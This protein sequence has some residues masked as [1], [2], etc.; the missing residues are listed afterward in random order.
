MALS[1]PA[2]ADRATTRAGR[3]SSRES[4]KGEVWFP[5]EMRF[6]DEIEKA[7]LDPHPHQVRWT[8]ARSTPT[9]SPRPGWS[10]RAGRGADRGARARDHGPESHRPASSPLA[11][12]AAPAEGQ[13]RSA[14]EEM[15]GAA[16]P[17]GAAADASRRSSAR[18]RAPRLK[19]GRGPAPDRRDALPA[20]P[21][22]TGTRATRRPTGSSTA[23]TSSTSTSTCGRTTGS[24]ASCSAGCSSTPAPAAEQQPEPSTASRSR[25][26]SAV[27]DQLWVRFDV[28]RAAFVTA[29]RQHV[30][31]GVGH[32]WNPTDYLHRRPPRPA[33][34]CSTPAPASPW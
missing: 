9:C 7:Q 11:L 33:G 27:V 8:S 4:K 10:R 31:W 21:A 15:F 19:L 18:P 32:F 5:E 3:R 14:E 16:Q 26:T 17:R 20:R 6:Y 12:L 30:K 1:G 29:G 28:E 25:S 22:S 34:R 23:P 2:H 13:D 24:A